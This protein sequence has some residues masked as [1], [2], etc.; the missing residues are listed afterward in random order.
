M[1]N[2]QI[3]IMVEVA[4]IYMLAQEHSVEHCL[5]YFVALKIIVFLP[6]FMANALF[7]Y[8]LKSLV[9]SNL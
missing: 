9:F 5:V 4:N 2:N 3:V 6:K 7:E 8:K 1:L